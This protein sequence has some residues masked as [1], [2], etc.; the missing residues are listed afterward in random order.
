MDTSRNNKESFL[1]KF[2]FAISLIVIPQIL[3]VIYFHQIIKIPIKTL[4]ETTKTVQFRTNWWVR[5]RILVK[6]PT[7]SQINYPN[8]KI[9]CL[10]TN[11]IDEIK[12]FCSKIEPD[13]SINVFLNR[14]SNK[15]DGDMSSDAHL[16]DSNTLVLSY[17]KGSPGQKYSLEIEIINKPKYLQKENIEVIVD[18]W[19]HPRPIPFTILILSTILGLILLIFYLFKLFKSLLSRK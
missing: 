13:F 15:I 18:A 5:H 10:L 17:F 8:H 14:T 9:D 16:F 19:G 1:K 2:I 11:S 7:L 3:E 12:P 4:K 6:L